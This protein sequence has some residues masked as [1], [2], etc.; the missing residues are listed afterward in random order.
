MNRVGQL[1]RALSA[2][3]SEKDTSYIERHLPAAGKALFYDMHPADRYHAL[4]VA[5]TAE[6][7]AEREEGSVDREF[8]IRC[9]L[10]HDVGRRKDDLGILGKVFAVLLHSL[11]PEISKGW[12]NP[13][14]RNLGDY[15]GYMMYVYY[16]H[17][18]IGAEKLLAAGF[19]EE[20]DVVRLHHQP[21][22]E[23]DP[24]ILR[25]LKTADDMN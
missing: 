15:P 18:D 20:A 2:R 14:V 10:L 7:L 12:A 24:P 1:F 6:R 5:Y 8:L 23:G 25:I 11:F 13:S 3:F 21:L 22:A 16:C 4:Q 19:P 17:P 9:A